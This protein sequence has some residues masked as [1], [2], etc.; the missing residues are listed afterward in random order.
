MVN[1]IATTKGLSLR[2]MDKAL[3]GDLFIVLQD[4]AHA[5]QWSLDDG[6]MEDGPDCG[7][8]YLRVLEST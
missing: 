3:T 8:R 1:E 5:Q 7:E 2:S 4:S 6:S